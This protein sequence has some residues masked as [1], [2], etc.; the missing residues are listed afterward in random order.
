MVSGGGALHP[1][2]D[3]YVTATGFLFF[4]E[5]HPTTVVHQAA[6]MEIVGELLAQ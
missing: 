4:D 5:I 2:C 3:G 6:G 1:E